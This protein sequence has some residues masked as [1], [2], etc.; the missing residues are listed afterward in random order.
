MPTYPSPKVPRSSNSSRK[1][2]AS[3]LFSSTGDVF[4]SA[5]VQALTG[6]QG[7]NNFVCAEPVRLRQNQL[8]PVYTC[9]ALSPCVCSLILR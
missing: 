2:S 8:S 3:A 9:Q 1:A 5:I 6:L 7:V 4:P